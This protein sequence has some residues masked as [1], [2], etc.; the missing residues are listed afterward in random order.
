VRLVALTFDEFLKESAALLAE[1]ERRGSDSGGV[2]E[3][4]DALARRAQGRRELETVELIDEMQEEAGLARAAMEQVHGEQVPTERVRHHL[5]TRMPE[6]QW[7]QLNW[8]QQD[9][10]RYYAARQ[11]QVSARYMGRYDE[12]EPQV[13]IWVNQPGLVCRPDLAHSVF[14]T[15]RND[16]YSNEQR[17]DDGRREYFSMGVRTS[18]PAWWGPGEPELRS[19]MFVEVR[20]PLW[21]AWREAPQRSYR[22]W[23][24]AW[25]VLTKATIDSRRF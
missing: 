21:R 23:V 19:P 16:V 8:E 7:R 12:I 5:R 2:E 22:E 13:A 4:R 18:P 15:I 9:A 20:I 11:R 3:R 17:Y 1:V 14:V 10:E 25:K 24:E 6:V